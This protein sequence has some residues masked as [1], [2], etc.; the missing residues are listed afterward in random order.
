MGLASEVLEYVSEASA[1]S[2]FAIAGLGFAA[3]LSIAVILN[4]LKQLLFKNPNEPPLV[5][6][7]FPFVGNTVTYGIHPY[8]F[9]FACREKVCSV[10]T[11]KSLSNTKLVWR[12]FHIHSS[13][14][15]SD[16]LS[17]TQGKR[18]HSQWQA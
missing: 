17:W 1:S 2:L 15:E 6:H 14:K 3:F 18:L 5:F 4:V 16:C 11:S 12:C 7:W 10:G 8:K 13:W 9:F